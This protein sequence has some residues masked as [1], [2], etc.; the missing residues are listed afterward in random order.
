MR[1]TVP[2]HATNRGP[3]GR[4][5]RRMTSGQGD[6]APARRERRRG[7]DRQ[8]AEAARRHVEKYEPLLEVITDKVNAEVPSPFAGV[9][10][11]ILVEEGATVPNNAEIAIIETADEARDGRHGA[12]AAPAP[13][14]RRP[15][16]PAPSRRGRADA[17]PAPPQPAPAR[18]RR[19]RPA[20][21]SAPSRARRRRRSAPDGRRR[22]AR[23]RRRQPGRP[24]DAGRPPPAPRARPDRG[25]DRRH[26]RWR[27]DHPR[28]RH[29][30]RRGQRTGQPVG[31]Q[32][33]PRQPPAERLG[34]PRR[35]PRAAPRLRPPAPAPPRAAARPAAG[36]GIAFPAGADEVLVPMTQMRKGIAAQ[37]TRA[38]QA[39]HAYV[40]MEVD[41][42]RL[43]AFREKAKREYQA[44]EGIG[45]QLRPVR[46]QGVGRRA[47]EATRRSTPTGPRR[48]CWPS[49][50]STSAS[51]SPSTTGLIVPV[52]R[53]ADTL[54]I[55]GL[56]LAI[57]DV[58]EPRPD[59][60]APASTTSAAGRS[61]S[62]TPAIS[63]RTSSCR[64]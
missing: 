16:A 58:A 49:A 27:P 28:G 15:P 30:L 25:P 53:D 10:K 26:R 59:E 9:L 61:P 8:V 60:Q 17:A 57:A 20:P 37:M 24:D 63:G 64:S 35:R 44:K 51:R 52:I 4:A 22:G 46:R 5:T 31:G 56:N 12:E 14:R 47:Q 32:A 62:T 19:A 36:A 40:Q 33:S 6:D 34:A 39:P 45:A 1:D 11:E 43:V 13:T 54:S 38:L 29:Q 3:I 7:D 48:A 23:R 2:K 18:R 50:G 55:H 42:T 21:T 41:V